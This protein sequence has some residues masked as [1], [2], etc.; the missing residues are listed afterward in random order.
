[1][2]GLTSSPRWNWHKI[3]RRRCP[4]LPSRLSV[5]P[6]PSD[7]IM[8]PVQLAQSQQPLHEATTVVMDGDE[9]DEVGEWTEQE[10]GLLR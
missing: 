10:L 1:M 5:Q 6:D 8:A 2:L 9:E 3:P 4:T 7:P